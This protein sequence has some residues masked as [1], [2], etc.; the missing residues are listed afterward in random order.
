MANKDEEIKML[1][2]KIAKLEEKQYTTKEQQL[3][4][5]AKL[6]N[7]KAFETKSYEYEG[8]KKSYQALTDFYKIMDR[9]GK[10]NVILLIEK[11]KRFAEVSGDEQ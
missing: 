11:I 5:L 1:K 4:K 8:K 2:E 10:D 3:Q 6:F 7:E 9:L